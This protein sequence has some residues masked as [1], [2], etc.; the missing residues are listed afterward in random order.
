MTAGSDPRSLTRR[1]FVARFG[2]VF[3]DSPWIAEAAFDA[4][5]PANANSAEGLHRALCAAL[6][7][8]SDERKLALIQAH[9]DLAGRLARA[10]A[11]S[12]ESTREQAGVGLDRLSDAEF[13]RFTALNDAYREKFAMPF[14]LAVKGHSKVEILAAFTARLNHDRETEVAAALA[15]I[16]RIALLRLRDLPP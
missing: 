16:E 15:Q 10:G 9:P 5:L 7:A 6:R 14:I 3:E 4:G 13:E 1:E 11:L 12:A 2:A 8:A